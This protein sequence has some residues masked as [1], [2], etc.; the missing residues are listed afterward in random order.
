MSAPATGP[1]GLRTEIVGALHLHTRHS[2]GTGDGRTLAAAAAGTGLDF[3]VVNDH[4]SLDVRAEG[5]EGW[6]GRVLVAV[7]TEVT[8]EGNRHLLAHG[9][10]SAARR[11][12][13]TVEEALARV[14]AEGGRTYAAHPQGRGLLGNKRSLQRWEHWGHPQLVGLELWN[15]L[16]DWAAS[17]RWWQPASYRLEEIGGRIQ[18]PP[19]WLLERWDREVERRPFPAICGSDNHAKRPPLATVTFFPHEALIARLVCRVRLARPLAADASTAIQEL[20]AA[21]A[22]GRALV[23][24]EELAPSAGFDFRVET[25]DGRS[26]WPGEKAAFAAGMRAVVESPREAELV[27]VA[28]GRTVASGR[29]RRLEARLE[30]PAPVRAEAR[31]DGKAWVFT[32]HVRA[33]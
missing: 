24:R 12:E 33:G 5:G 25:G 15:Y 14:A 22:A 20:F 29:G 30:T 18:G 11:Y 8:A 16:Q 27:I 3:V 10:T 28:G 6:H 7:G 4:D 13:L 1:L 9:N 23:A 32:N 31:L 19:Q 26:V 21:L 17:F 2:D